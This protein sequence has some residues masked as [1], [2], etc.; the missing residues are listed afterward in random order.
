MRPAT[1]QRLAGLGA[2]LELG[3]LGRAPRPPTALER[4][5]PGRDRPLPA[6]GLDLGHAIG[7]DLLLDVARHGAKDT[8][9]GRLDVHDLE[10]D[11]A[12]RNRH[13][14]RLALLVAEQRA[15]DRRL[16]REPALGR[17][18][19]GGTDDLVRVDV[20]VRRRP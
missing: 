8:G 1:P 11:G 20:A 5:A 9:S 6:Q 10:P 14:D 19:L 3:E 12:R 18:G 16:V 15:A 4:R 17:V 2:G 13:L 7:P